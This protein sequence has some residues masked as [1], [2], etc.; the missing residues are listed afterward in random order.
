MKNCPYGITKSGT[1]LTDKKSIGQR[2]DATGLYYYNARYCLLNN[3]SP[4]YLGD[5]PCL[6]WNRGRVNL[7]LNTLLVYNCASSYLTY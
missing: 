2:L 1:V 5:F 6:W 4:G 7:Y 3:K